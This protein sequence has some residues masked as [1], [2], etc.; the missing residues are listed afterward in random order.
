MIIICCCISSCSNKE[1][2]LLTVAEGDVIVG[3]REGSVVGVIA[4]QNMAL[5]GTSYA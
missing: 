5:T 3:G 2:E 1:N 4:E